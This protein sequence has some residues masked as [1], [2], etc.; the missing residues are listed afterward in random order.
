[1]Q[2]QDDG[3]RRYASPKQVIKMV[4]GRNETAHVI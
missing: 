3:M 1:M 2:Q 4:W